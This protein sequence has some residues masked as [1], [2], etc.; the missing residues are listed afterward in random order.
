MLFKKRPCRYLK[1]INLKG[2]HRTIFEMVADSM[3]G[4]NFWINDA[5]SHGSLSHTTR[6]LSSMLLKIASESCTS[7]LREDVAVRLQVKRLRL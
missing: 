5:F 4:R 1:A 7:F 2:L 3:I 6:S